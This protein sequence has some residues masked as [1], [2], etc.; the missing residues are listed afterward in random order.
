MNNQSVAASEDP[1]HP[2]S[3]AFIVDDLAFVSGALPTASDGSVVG[4]RAAALDAALQTLAARLATVGLALTDV[5]KL[6]YFVTD[7]TLRDEANVQLI[8]HFA[9]PRPA[10]SFVEVSRLPYGANVEID[11]VAHRRARRS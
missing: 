5:V 2:Y 6:T 8:K 1:A 4:G 11:A 7:I 9:Q 10:R 3:A